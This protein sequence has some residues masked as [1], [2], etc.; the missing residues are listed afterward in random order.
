MLSGSCLI[1]N[2][3]IA[4]NSAG[5]GGTGAYA[6]LQAGTGGAGGDGGGIF[7]YSNTTGIVVNSTIANNSAGQGGAGGQA[8]S[9]PVSGNGGPGG[10]G[11]GVYGGTN[12]V[13][14]NDT[15][16][17]NKAGAGGLPG[18]T[19]TVPYPPFTIMG[20]PG[21][22]GSVG[23]V[24][25]QSASIGNTI[26]AANVGRD[27]DAA[28][29]FNSQGRNLIGVVTAQNTGWVASDLTGTADAPLDPRLAPLGDYGGPTPTIALLAGSPALDH[30]DNALLSLSGQPSITTDQRGFARI[31]NGTVDIGAFEAQPPAVGGDLNHDGATNFAD[32]LTLAQSYGQSVPVWEQGD[33]TGDGSVQFADLLVLAQ[34][35]GKGAAPTAAASALT[36]PAAVQ[37]TNLDR[38]RTRSS[39]GLP[40][41]RVLWQ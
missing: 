37:T 11:G 5:K 6:S 35:Y 16:T 30:G 33:L 26:I 31:F 4:N 36:Q 41:R 13:F 25:T 14:L 17:G 40:P 32:L 8:S 19:F 7:L 38:R 21:P 2:S 20:Q 3:T 10:D 29:S 22:A 18:P 39:K 34:N 28:G 23:G 12:M 9:G 15:I 1:E 24:N 27:P